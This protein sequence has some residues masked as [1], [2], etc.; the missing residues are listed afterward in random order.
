LGLSA[1]RIQIDVQQAATNLVIEVP[2]EV[3]FDEQ[4][5]LGLLAVFGRV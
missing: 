2:Y 4:K 1:D 3:K 5:T